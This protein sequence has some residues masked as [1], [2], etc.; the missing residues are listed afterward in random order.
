MDN[1][2]LFILFIIFL[3]L[4]YNIGC[5]IDE[6]AKNNNY[7]SQLRDILHENLPDM[8]NSS[9]YDDILILLTAMLFFYLYGFK[10]IKDFVILFL[11]IWTLRLITISVTILPN[12]NI[13]NNNEKRP[14]YMRIFCGGCNDLIFSGHMSLMLLL[15][16]YISKSVPSII[17]KVGILIYALLYSIVIL[18]LRNHYT[19]DIVLAWF[20]TIATYALYYGGMS[21]I[22]K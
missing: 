5:E 22:L 4:D 2:V 13:H 17:G 18:L 10:H 16:L 12:P 15:L 9:A 3:I 11:I 21:S 6:K 14:K 7:K 1:I 8:S 20:I 19:V